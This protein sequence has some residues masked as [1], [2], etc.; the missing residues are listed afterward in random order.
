MGADTAGSPPPNVSKFLA[1]RAASGC[2]FLVQNLSS[3]LDG[4]QRF[5]EVEVFID[6][7]G[8]TPT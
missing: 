6:L 3:R 4:A 1:M 2:R 7:L 8:A 5:F